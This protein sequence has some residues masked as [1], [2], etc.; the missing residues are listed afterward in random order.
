MSTF[1]A[2]LLEVVLNAAWLLAEDDALSVYY[3]IARV[4]SQA[5]PSIRVECFAFS[6]DWEALS[7]TFVELGL[8]C[9]AVVVYF[10]NLAIRVRITVFWQAPSRVKIETTG[11]GKTVPIGFIVGQAFLANW[12]A[13]KVVKV[14]EI[15]S[16]T[17]CA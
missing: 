13:A 6:V 2:T 3:D 5:L 14:K 1:D 12:L 11:T 4:T 17:N 9:I 15:S 8:A 10:V 7:S 16:F